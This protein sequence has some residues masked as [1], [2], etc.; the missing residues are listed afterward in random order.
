VAIFHVASK[1]LHTFLKNELIRV[2]PRPT[3]LSKVSDDK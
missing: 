1:I 3:V 2:H